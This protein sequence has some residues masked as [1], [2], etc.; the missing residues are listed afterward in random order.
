M[1]LAKVYLS[2]KQLQTSIL[3]TNRPHEPTAEED[4]NKKLIIIHQ[5]V[6]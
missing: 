5:I 6:S 2:N 3:K 1:E 4:N